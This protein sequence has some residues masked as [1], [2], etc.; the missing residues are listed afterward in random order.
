MHSYFFLQQK[1]PHHIN[2]RSADYPR[3]K[4]QK[5]P[6]HHLLMGLDHRYLADECQMGFPLIMV[7]TV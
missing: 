3:N 6:G 2:E 1:A 4:K 5:K 7:G